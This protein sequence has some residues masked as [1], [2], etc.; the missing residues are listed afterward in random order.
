MGRQGLLAWWL[1]LGV[2]EAVT[3]FRYLSLI[4]RSLVLRPGSGFPQAAKGP[5]SPEE[6]EARARTLAPRLG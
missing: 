4:L 5:H 1:W 2:Q 6:N 3:C